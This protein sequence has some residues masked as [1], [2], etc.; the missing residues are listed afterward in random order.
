MQKEHNEIVLML[1]GVN[2]DVLDSSDF[3]T[4]NFE[5][6]KKGSMMF[7]DEVFDFLSYEYECTLFILWLY[8]GRS[9]S[10]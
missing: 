2:D 10:L 5:E 9:M 1:H 3:A 4:R 7:V 6:N 8:G